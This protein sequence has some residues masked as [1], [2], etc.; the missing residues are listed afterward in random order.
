[1]RDKSTYRYVCKYCN[2]KTH[3][4]DNICSA[5][6]TKL[7]LVRKLLKVAKQVCGKEVK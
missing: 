4:M 3:R 7:P 5:C 2:A 6:A 1:M